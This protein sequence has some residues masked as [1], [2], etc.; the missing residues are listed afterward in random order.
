MNESEKLDDNVMSEERF[1][2]IL[3][4]KTKQVGNIKYEDYEFPNY[5]PKSEI[6]MFIKL[7]KSHYLQKEKC[8]GFVKIYLLN[9]HRIGD[10][11]IKLW[12]E[13]KFKVADDEYVNKTMINETII[14]I[15]EFSGREDY[16]TLDKGEFMFPFNF[17]IPENAVPF[18][19]YNDSALSALI[20]TEIT[21]TLINE[22]QITCSHGLKIKT[23][24]PDQKEPENKGEDK[25]DE[26]NINNEENK[27]ESQLKKEAKTDSQAQNLT[28]TTRTELTKWAFLKAGSVQLTLTLTNG[29]FRTGDIAEAKFK[30]DNSQGSNAIV[31]V[32]VSLYKKLTFKDNDGNVVLIRDQKITGAVNDIDCPPS[33]TY[34]GECYLAMEDSM[35]F[36][37]EEK[38]KP[39]NYT[40][41]PNLES[42]LVKCEYYVKMTAKT[43]ALV[44]S[45]VKPRC[46][47]PLRILN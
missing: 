17:D 44:Q 15:K 42:K 7:N 4:E 23:L 39:K 34:E 13:E 5:D 24:P 6:Q 1:A 36:Y 20:K 12:Q 25:K 16:M 29:V 43:D 46:Y 30:V 41:Q 31:K 28:T 2:P 21:G 10:I 32:K 27:E 26:N 19:Q 18:F 35:M 47:L 38:N 8:I 3:S 37:K 33:K 9:Q 11:S 40:L 22:P 14:S 45:G